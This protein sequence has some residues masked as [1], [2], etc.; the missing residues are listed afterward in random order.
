[1]QR[2]E[3]RRG[4]IAHLQLRGDRRA[5]LHCCSVGISMHLERVAL[6][7]VTIAAIIA[8]HRAHDRILETPIVRSVTLA[9]EIARSIDARAC[10]RTDG[11]GGALQHRGDR[12]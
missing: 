8:H 2:R 7:G 5:R 12:T 11:R 1:M 3:Q 9:L 4:R 6:D 10:K